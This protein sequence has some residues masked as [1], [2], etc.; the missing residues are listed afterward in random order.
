M[1]D[2]SK[3]EEYSTSLVADDLSLTHIID[4]DSLDFKTFIDDL[5][6]NKKTLA[7]MKEAGFLRKNWNKFSGKNT[8]LIIQSLD[9]NNQFIRLGGQRTKNKKPEGRFRL[10]LRLLTS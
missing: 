7:E 2:L 10:I 5:T 6:K 3:Q 8:S 1:S 9:L 4:N